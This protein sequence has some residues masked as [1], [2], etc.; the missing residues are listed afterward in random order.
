[1]NPTTEDIKDMLEDSSVGVGSLVFA[2]NLFIGTMPELPDLC[3]GLYDT[4]GLG[5]D[6][7]QSGT[8][9]PTFQVRVRGAVGGYQAG[10]ELAQSIRDAL[11][12][13]TN[14]TFNGTRYIYI[15]ASGD[16]LYIGKDDKD[17]PLFSIN[18]RT[19]KT[20]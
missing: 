8:W 7:A 14:Q 13:L 17:R 5:G 19:A 9:Y 18:F 3:V 16:I 6:E 1:M 12:Q 2:T 11:H 15:F 20:G 10:Y 4:G